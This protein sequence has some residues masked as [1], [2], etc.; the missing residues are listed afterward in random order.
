MQTRRQTITEVVV[1]TAV[2]FV[3]SAAIQQW[4]ATPMFHLNTNHA[5]NLGI[6]VLF[7][8]VSLV[9]GY[10]FRRFFNWYHRSKA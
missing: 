10:I 6:T 8:V 1:T 5:Q 2:A 4:V 3:I 9:R 7:T